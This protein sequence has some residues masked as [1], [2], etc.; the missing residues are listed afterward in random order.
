IPRYR[1][2]EN[3]VGELEFSAARQRLHLDPAIAELSVTAGLLLMTALN[4]R[5]PA[6]RLPVR[7][8][9][10]FQRHVHPVTALQAADHD[11]HVLLARPRQ[12]ELARLRVAV[13][14]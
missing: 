1:A 4:V 8:F 3:L 14:A 6:D 9:R 5:R 13:E 10:G 12:Q 11:F 7:D 2:A